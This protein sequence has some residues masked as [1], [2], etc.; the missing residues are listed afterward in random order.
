MIDKKKVI[1]M[2]ETVM[3][4]EV[5]VDI[6]T[7]GLVYDISIVDEKNIKIIMTYTSPM[8]PLG[9]EIKADVRQ[10]MKVLGFEDVEIEVTF[11]PPWEPS[12][13]LREALGV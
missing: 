4:P 11:E 7:M 12:K 6:W 9:D 3:D 10:A 1:E 13:E 8:C 2:L 5:G